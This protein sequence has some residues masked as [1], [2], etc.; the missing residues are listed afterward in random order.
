[1]A[2]RPNE[3]SSVVGMCV[4]AGEFQEAAPSARQA[5]PQAGAYLPCGS[6]SSV[7]FRKSTAMAPW[8]E[9]GIPP[10]ELPSRCPKR[11]SNG[12]EPGQYWHRYGGSHEAAEGTLAALPRSR[13]PP[14]CRPRRPRPGRGGRPDGAGH[15][16]H[17]SRRRLAEGDV[18]APMAPPADGRG[19]R[20]PRRRSA[21]G[22]GARPRGADAGTRRRRHGRPPPAGAED[23]L[24][25]RRHPPR[26]PADGGRAARLLRRASRPRPHAS[27][28]ILHAGL[29]PPRAGGWPRPRH[30]RGPVRRVP[31]SWRRNRAT[32]SCSAT[33]SPIR[34]SR[35]SPTCSARPS[36]KP[37]WRCP[38]GAGRVRSSPAT[39]CT[40]SRSRRC[41]LPQ[42]LPFAEV[43]ER[44]TEEWYRERQETAQARLV[45]GLMRKYRI[46]ADA[47][48]RPWLGS[49]A[50]HAEVR[51]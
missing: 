50:G 42:A 40:W 16:D 38:P 44:L 37:S 12:L 29:L 35:R 18:D 27:A 1:M 22:G 15:P 26:R 48:V 39:G 19:T 41:R 17:R 13:R 36:R 20:R 45:D 21:Q 14:V 47:A 3:R 33:P 10:P 46:V 49:F 9:A 23:G 11:S 6:R 2:R 24:H 51:P 31:P 7:G 30:P 4:M 43:R 34:T 32:A 8:A 25:A 5:A 28:R